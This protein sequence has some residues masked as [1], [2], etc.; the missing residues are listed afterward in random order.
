MQHLY[1]WTA[2]D[3]LYLVALRFYALAGY[4]T[5]TDFADQILQQ[6]YPLI[7][8]PVTAKQ[9]ADGTWTSGILPGTVITLPFLV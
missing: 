4:T 5:W 6:N 9:R 8:D 3:N 1:T 7:T 2:A